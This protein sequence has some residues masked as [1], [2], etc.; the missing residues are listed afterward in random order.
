[1]RRYGHSFE[2]RRAPICDVALMGYSRRING[3]GID[4]PVGWTIIQ[5]TRC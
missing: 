1:M 2:L 5:L 3:S 4:S